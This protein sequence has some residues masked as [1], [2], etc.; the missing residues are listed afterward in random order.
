MRGRTALFLGLLLS[1]CATMPP[2]K[3]VLP[4]PLAGEVPGVA[5]TKSQRQVA[6]FVVALA[7]AGRLAEAKAK[8]ASLP[9]GHPVRELLQRELDYLAGEGPLWIEVASLTEKYPSYQG[10]WELAVLVGEREGRWREA[11]AAAS[12]LAKLVPHGSW[13]KRSEVL[14]ARFQAE[15]EAQVKKLLQEGQSRP[16]L[17]AAKALL[18]EF[19]E[20][21]STRELA[22]RAALAAGEVEDAKLLVLP[23]PEDG[24]GLE[25]KAEVAAA[26][27]KWELAANLLRRLPP[28][29]PGRCEKLSQAEENARWLAASPRVRK[30]SESERLTRAQLAS[31]LVFYFPEVAGQT[32]G[33]VP[34]FE[35]VVGLPEQ[36]EVIAVVRAGLMTGDPLTRRFSPGRPVASRE[37]E[38]VLNRLA[39]FLGWGKL[40]ICGEG[41]APGCLSLPENGRPIS[42]RELVAVFLQLRRPQ[43][44]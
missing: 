5:L 13:A 14:R 17:A 27:Q 44:C 4:D 18:A 36:A 20:S 24:A 25:L 6:N 11:A 40:A 3:G 1:A 8:L 7:E 15:G 41:P 26:E 31:L 9:E 16:A 43:G 32:Q 23:L 38:A 35:D 19:P 37:L 2:R 29:Y 30:A 12:V 10:A 42:G 28:S 21:R 22:V 39:K 33:T 34:L